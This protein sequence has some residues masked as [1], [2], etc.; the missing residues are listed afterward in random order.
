MDKPIRQENQGNPDADSKK[1][2]F[3]IEQQSIISPNLDTN[4]SDTQNNPS[5]QSGF[6]KKT[7]I[8]DWIMVIATV[9]IAC[10]TAIYTNYAGKQWKVMSETL[11]EMK[12]SGTTSKN[13]VDS[14]ITETN[15]IASSMESAN[16]QNKKSVEDSLAQSERVLNANIKTA[17]LDQRAWVGVIMAKPPTLKDISNKPVYIKEGLPPAIGV[18]LKNSGKSPALKVKTFI[19]LKT[20]PANIKFLPDYSEIPKQ[21][22][23][24]IQPQETLTVAI[25]PSHS[26]IVIASHINTIK[27]GESVAYLFGIITYEDIFRKRHET[28]FCL[29]LAPSLDNFDVCDTYNDA[30]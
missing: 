6:F 10:A 29:Y 12:I 19:R 26:L 8:T 24:V 25:Q 11:N 23:A 28:T 2:D 1:E 21:S 3:P 20:F 17:E 18:V 16:T 27:S 4:N 30:T 5:P 22:L 13:Q 14:M 7:K 9:V 15:R